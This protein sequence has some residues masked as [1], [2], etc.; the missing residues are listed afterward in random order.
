MPNFTEIE[1]TFRGQT[2]TRT[3]ISDLFM[4]TQKSRAK[5]HLQLFPKCWH[6]LTESNLHWHS[7]LR[8]KHSS[9]VI[10]PQPEIS[11]V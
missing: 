2:D 8:Y 10:A 3:D 9:T 6:R 11:Q 5:M 4:S 7:Q 1:G